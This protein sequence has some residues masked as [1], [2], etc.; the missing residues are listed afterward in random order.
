MEITQMLLLWLYLLAKVN[1]LNLVMEENFDKL[2]KK[3]IRELYLLK[4]PE[5]YIIAQEKDI[6]IDSY[7]GAPKDLERAISYTLSPDTPLYFGFKNG[8]MLL[9]LSMLEIACLVEKH[10]CSNVDKTLG[11]GFCNFL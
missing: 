3:K 10:L 11:L 5:K 1:Y 4:I 6:L 2:D 7:F 9:N 8:N